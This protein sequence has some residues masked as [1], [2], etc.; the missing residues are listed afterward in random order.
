MKNLQLRPTITSDCRGANSLPIR[1]GLLLKDWINIRDEDDYVFFC[2]WF[3]REHAMNSY[4]STGEFDTPING[5]VST[6]NDE[7]VAPF[8]TPGQGHRKVWRFVPRSTLG[9]GCDEK[10][11]RWNA[12]LTKKDDLV[13]ICGHG[14]IASLRGYYS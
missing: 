2:G 8:T 11:G 12:Q 4:E 9:T 3:E 14:Y 5:I 6:S 7:N 1:L 10:I 13:Y